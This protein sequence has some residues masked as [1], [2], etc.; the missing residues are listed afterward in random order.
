MKVEQEKLGKVV[1]IL[2]RG[3]LPVYGDKPAK[4]EK[5]GKGDK[6]KNPKEIKEALDAEGDAVKASKKR[7][8]RLPRLTKEEQK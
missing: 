6:P 3:G 7:P 4:E 1:P 8:G 5:P 2:E